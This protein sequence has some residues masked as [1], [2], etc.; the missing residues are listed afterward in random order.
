MIL[1]NRIV[2]VGFE[3]LQLDL[4][5]KVE[6]DFLFITIASPSKLKLSS[7]QFEAFLIYENSFKDCSE[8]L[9][10]FKE[11]IFFV[12]AMRDPGVPYVHIPPPLN[13]Q[14]LSDKFAQ[15]L[16]VS[17]PPSEQTGEIQEGTIV[18]NK[19]FPAWGLGVVQEELTEGNF[20]IKFIHSAKL[21]KKEEVVCHKS[22]LRIISSL[23]EIKA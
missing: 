4:L 20:R 3:A 5:N 2:V 7:H 8:I 18:K 19:V 16:P 1:R 11:K 9:E 14:R 21:I 22:L 13:A 23:E 6:G 17:R 15:I 12:L 10:K